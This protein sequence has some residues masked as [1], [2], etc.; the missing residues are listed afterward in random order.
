MRRRRKAPIHAFE[1]GKIYV[2]I[3]PI[4]YPTPKTSDRREQFWNTFQLR[5]GVR[6]DEE[7]SA[8]RMEAQLQ[9]NLGIELKKQL[10]DYF[11]ATYDRIARF[12]DHIAFRGPPQRG[13][14][15]IAAL[16]HSVFFRA[17]ITGYHSLDLAIDIGGTDALKRI[18]RSNTDVL[19]MFLES[20][21]PRAMQATFPGYLIRDRYQY[22][23]E[24]A[25][26]TRDFF[27][28]E[29]GTKSNVRSLQEEHISNGPI[30]YWRIANY[31]LVVPVVLSLIVLYLAFNA[32]AQERRAIDALQSQIATQQSELIGRY[33]HLADM[34]NASQTLI[35][36]EFL[37]QRTCGIDN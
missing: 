37:I 15:E 21:L 10:A 32:V 33:E 24:V 4:S 34:S 18:F 19:V 28:K 11:A 2:S 30:R 36:E 8:T 14:E 9:E 3:S 27:E 17:R 20:Y 12:D 22:R 13:Y 6:S 35:L 1:L 5:R 31:T 16:L 29:V 26:P 23:V 25:E 7:F